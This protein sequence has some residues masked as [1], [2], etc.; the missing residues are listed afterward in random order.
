VGLAIDPRDAGLVHQR[1]PDIL[2]SSRNLGASKDLRGRR[3]QA[4]GMPTDNTLR[5]GLN[6]IAPRWIAPSCYWFVFP[7]TTFTA[8]I[9]PPR[10]TFSC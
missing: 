8:R 2:L 6:R 7:R 4:Y 3:I 10:R 1:E 9:A 5:H